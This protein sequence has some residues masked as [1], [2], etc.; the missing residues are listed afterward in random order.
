M[1]LT[2]AAWEKQ[3]RVGIGMAMSHEGPPLNAKHLVQMHMPQPHGIV[4]SLRYG[5]DMA[6]NHIVEDAIEHGATHIVWLDEDVFPPI[7]GIMRLLRHHD[8]K[9]IVS[10]VYYAKQPGEK[11]MAAWGLNEE[12]KYCVIEDPKIYED[13]DDNGMPQVNIAEVDAV[14]FGFCMT[15]VKLF[16]ELE[17]PWFWYEMQRDGHKPEEKGRERTSEDFWLCRRAKEKDW[18]VLLDL[19]IRCDHLTW[20]FLS[21]K[22]GSMEIARI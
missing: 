5:V 21:G 15:P 20:A 12:G 19:S 1:N 14:G 3:I 13:G 16:E 17:Q 11:H 8:R 22:D 18:K 10:G 7:D 9:A 2:P 6:R 4:W